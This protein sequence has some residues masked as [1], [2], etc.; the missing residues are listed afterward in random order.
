MLTSFDYSA[1][2]TTR[3]TDWPCGSNEM[4]GHALLSLCSGGSLFYRCRIGRTY[5]CVPVPLPLPLALA[6]TFT[7]TLT[8]ASP[9]NGRELRQGYGISGNAQE[10]SSIMAGSM[11]CHRNR[12]IVLCFC[13]YPIRDCFPLAPIGRRLI[14]QRALTPRNGP[15]CGSMCIRCAESRVG[16]S[17][18]VWDK[19]RPFSAEVG[20]HRDHPSHER[21]L[22]NGYDKRRQQRTTS[23]PASHRAWVDA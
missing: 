3:S 1:L 19:T 17:L 5:R 15:S 10:Y 8:L 14:T 2:H 7:F 18:A 23:Q 21:S 22:W 13:E 12:S 6:L 4:H 9:W 11:G 16:Y 20:D